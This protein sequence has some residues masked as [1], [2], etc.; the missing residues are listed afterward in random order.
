MSGVG[1]TTLTPHDTMHLTYPDHDLSWNPV[2]WVSVTRHSPTR[3]VFWHVAFWYVIRQVSWNTAAPYIPRHYSFHAVQ[4]RI[5]LRPEFF[6]ALISQLLKLFAYI[7]AMIN[8]IFIHNFL[9]RA[10]YAHNC[11]DYAYGFCTHCLNRPQSSTQLIGS[12]FKSSCNA[13][14][15]ISFPVRTWSCVFMQFRLLTS[16]VWMYRRRS[17]KV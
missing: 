12:N 2:S 6:Q 5:P 14:S 16:I 8:H 3:S 1:I 7:T 4:V 15:C 13:S 17:V 9:L 11:I 10:H